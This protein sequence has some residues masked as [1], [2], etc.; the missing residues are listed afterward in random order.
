MSQ[1]THELQQLQTELDETKAYGRK[2]NY[3]INL[4]KQKLGEL[5]QVED[6]L[7]NG[8]VSLKNEIDMVDTLHRK[9]E[10]S[11]KWRKHLQ[12]ENFRLRFLVA[13]GGKG[14]N[15]YQAVVIVTWILVVDFSVGGNKFNNN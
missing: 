7:R 2:L 15:W 14:I 9:V 4:Q 10:T 6:R 11:K 5:R 3:I 13:N 1:S 8:I 12:R